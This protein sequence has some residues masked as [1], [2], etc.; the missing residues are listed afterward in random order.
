M[1]L[2]VAFLALSGW[3]SVVVPVWEA[4]DEPDHV[5]Y[6]NFVAHYW[7]LPPTL[8]TI[9]PSGNPESAQAP[10]YYFLAALVTGWAQP[11]GLAE[12]RL[13]PYV[14]W[15]DHAA[16]V[17]VVAHSPVA[18]GWPPSPGVLV[19]HFE[20]VLSTLLGLVTVLF[21]YGLARRVVKSPGL[22]L[23][24]GGSVAFLPGF[25]FSSA[26]VNNDAALIALASAAAFLVIG[27]GGT[28]FTVRRLVLLALVLTLTVGAKVSGL[29]VVVATGACLL[30]AGVAKRRVLAV[31]APALMTALGWG[32]LRAWDPL[33]LGRQEWQVVIAATWE[34]AINA[35]GHF[36]RSIVGV[37]GWQN[38]PLPE[39]VYVMVAALVLPGV[40][41]SWSRRPERRNAS[42]LALWTAL[43]AGG[44]LVRWLISS[45]PRAFLEHGRY[46]YPALAP[47]ASLMAMGWA[48]MPR[49]AGAALAGA[50]VGTL[51]VTTVIAIPAVIGPAY[52]YRDELTRFVVPNEGRDGGQIQARPA[53]GLELLGFDLSPPCPSRGDAVRLA[54]RWHATGSGVPE[55][56][57]VV[58]LQPT[59]GSTLKMSERDP[60][61]NLYPTSVW[62]PE[63]VV[64]DQHE[65]AIAGNV[66]PGLY[67]LR[68][69]IRYEDASTVA[70]GPQT[71]TAPLMSIDWRGNSGAQCAP[72]GNESH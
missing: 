67:V 58:L 8:P 71:E 43:V 4:P 28:A 44:V 17:A 14:T 7:R 23:L 27:I 22:S 12:I 31:A 10:L 19:T 21:S 54:L 32:F 60:G 70:T 59:S 11:E 57:T 40:L 6:I 50:L 66:A 69:G 55:A 34:D 51:G 29:T 38:L 65:F 2:G 36:W 49:P 61:R 25:V 56:D 48:A 33:V 63:E 1:V 39:V 68:A 62:L 47:V 72:I 3:Y 53:A 5:A 20:R 42:Q 64:L 45:D 30:V 18:E 41:L 46:L 16:R 52:A 26:T 37:F 9:Q 24:A 13:N 15:P 35:P